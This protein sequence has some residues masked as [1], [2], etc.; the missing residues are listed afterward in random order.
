MIYLTDGLELELRQWMRHPPALS[1]AAAKILL[2]QAKIDG[3]LLCEIIYNKLELR[4]LGR[5]RNALPSKQNWRWEPKP[6]RRPQNKSPEVNLEKR[7]VGLDV[8]DWTNAIP[9][10]SG[11]FNDGGRRANIDLAWREGTQ[12]GFI[13]LKWDSN[14][15]VYAAIEAVGYAMAWVQARIHADKMGYLKEDCLRPGLNFEKVAWCVAAP[16]NFYSGHGDLDKLETALAD[17]LSE[18]IIYKLNNSVTTT[19]RFVKL[20]IDTDPFNPTVALLDYLKRETSIV[21]Q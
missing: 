17:G 15:P 7:L 21:N 10:A 16:E 12:C 14:H 1:K 2:Q 11:L 18:F 4:F 6:H 20:P 19:F 13:E 5:S 8:A 9:T 3:R